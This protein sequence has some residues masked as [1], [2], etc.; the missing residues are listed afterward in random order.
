[1]VRSCRTMLPMAL[2]LLAGAA[3]SGVRAQ[4]P[5]PQQPQGAYATGTYRSLLREAGHPDKE[6]NARIEQTFQQLFHGNPRTQTIFYAAGLNDNG[7]L[8]YITDVANRD[9]RTEGMSYGMMITVQLNHK[10][11]FDAIWNWASTSMLVTDPANPSVGY[12]AWSMHTDG[13]PRSDSPAPDGEEYFAMSLLFAAH[14][15][16]NAEG[17][18]NY[19]AQAERILHTMRHH[20]VLTG[21]APF[22]IH[23]Q[24]PPFNPRHIDPNSRTPPH[25]TTVGPM[26]NEPDAMVEFV[27][28]FGANSFTDPSYQ[29]PAFYE[30]WARWGPQEDR[31]FWAHAAEVSRRFFVTV[32]GPETGLSPD[33]ANFDGT[34][35]ATSFNPMSANFSYDSW[36]TASNWAVDQSWWNANPQ[37]RTLSDRIQS[38]LFRQ[39]IHA[40]ADQYTLAGKPLSTRHS[41]G[42]VSTT[43][44]TGLAATPGPMEKAFVDE[45]WSAAIPSGE[46]RYYDGMLY[47]MSL[48][49]AGGRFRIWM[50]PHAP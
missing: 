21:T 29:L 42:M 37:A 24:D 31:D 45:L 9:V 12:F 30:L 34:P 16:G 11:E 27:P 40:F 35:R 6:V 17:I 41:T 44:V 4:Q 32:T 25:T 28:S 10:A 38:F 2:L 50:P 19:Q 22:R 8:A 3:P 18:Y 20:P 46:Q 15:W 48:M 36:R 39:G 5:S 47:L 1:M 14:R 23:P 33:Y 7:P 13:T 49:H 43:A 26:V